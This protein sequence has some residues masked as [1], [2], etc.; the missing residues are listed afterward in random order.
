MDGLVFYRLRLIDR[1]GS[2]TFSTIVSADFGTLKPFAVQLSDDRAF[3]GVKIETEMDGCVRLQLFDLSGRLLQNRTL[4]LKRGLSESQF[5]LSDL[6]S[7]IFVLRAELPNGG[8]ETVRLA[9]I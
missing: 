3:V 5:D 4:D 2:E 8:T 1:D 9:K 7:G 6:P